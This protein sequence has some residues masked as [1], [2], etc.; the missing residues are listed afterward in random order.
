MNQTTLAQRR[1]FYRRHL[2]G[3]TFQE[4]ADNSGVSRGCVRF[5]FRRQRNGGTCENQYDRDSPGLLS[6]FDPLVRYAILHMKLAHP[7]WGPE[8]IHYKLTK[9]RSCRGLQLPHPSSIGRYVHQ[10]SRFHRPKPKVIKRSR[11]KPVKAVHQRWQIDFKTN[12][13]QENGEKLTLHTLVD[14]YSGACLDA[15]LLPKETV[16]KRRARVTW[17]EAQKTLRCGFSAWGT[18]PQSVQTDS[19]STLVGRAG[20]DF[21]TD[22]TLWLRGLGVEHTIIRTGICTDNSEVERGHRT[23]N[24][25]A[26]FGQEKRTLAELQFMLRQAVQ[27]L[28]FELPSR[29]K[30]CKGRPPTKAYP[31]LLST[32]QPYQL[33]KELVH[34]DMKRIDAYLALFQWRRK[35]CKN[36]RIQLGGHRCRYWVGR[37]YAYQYVLINFDPDDRHLVFFSENNPEQEICRLPIKALSVHDLI[38]IKDPEVTVV[39]QQLPL[40]PDVLRG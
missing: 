8:R 26:V 25:Y 33:E 9:R 10:W 5:W 29:A 24:D 40:F 4:I 11:P 6:S 1:E 22:F 36:G 32:P 37:E 21:P 14:E 31:A 30:K 20:L 16:N 7:R 35:V 39:P 28:T 2:Q 34:F 38:G 13:R 23:V 12:I 18:L 17:R 19:E 3:E 27:E 15:Q